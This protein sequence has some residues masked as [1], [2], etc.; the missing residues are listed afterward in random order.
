MA[1]ADQYQVIVSVEV[2]ELSTIPVQVQQ[3]KPPHQRIQTKRTTIKGS[4]PVARETARR[5]ACDCSITRHQTHNGEPTS[6]GR[7]SR[8]WP[9]AMSRAIE[10]RDQHCQYPRCTKTHQL[11]IHHM[12]HWADGD[13]TSIEK[14]SQKK[15]DIERA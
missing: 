12:T 8:L 5:I 6:I 13:A 15:T 3:P 11:Q 14:R 4:G 9:A 2:A 10:N 1:T 7:K